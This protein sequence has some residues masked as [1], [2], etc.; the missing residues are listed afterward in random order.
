MRIETRSIASIAQ[1]LDQLAD[2]IDATAFARPG[3]ARAR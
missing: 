1:E 3:W 2:E